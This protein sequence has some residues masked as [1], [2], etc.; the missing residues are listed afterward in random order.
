MLPGVRIFPAPAPTST[1]DQSTTT[2]EHLAA[3]AWALPLFYQ[4][5]C[6][7]R[8]R[9]LPYFP[10]AR[11]KREFPQPMA[12]IFYPRPEKPPYSY[13]ALIAMA[14]TS[15]PD[16]RLT[17]SGIYKFIIDK[18]PYYRDNC[19]GW[20]NSI[21]HNLS[22]NNCFVRV[23]RDRSEGGGK[24]S[25]WTLDP[26]QAANMFE[27]GNY[28]RRRSRRQKVQTE[29]IPLEVQRPETTIPWPNHN[30]GLSEDRSQ[31]KSSLFTI[32]SLIRHNSND[33]QHNVNSNKDR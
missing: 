20:Q 14:I 2:A 10:L 16:Q 12:D 6:E 24:G 19:Q 1:T 21:R 13:I 15:A 29:A 30:V 22:L 31:K 7:L 18:F 23:P 26:A 32:E 11:A 33:S 5:Q 4:Q 27:R 28:R 25:Y 17:L 3:A 9:L 8:A